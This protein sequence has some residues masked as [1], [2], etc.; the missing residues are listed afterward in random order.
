[1]PVLALAGLL[2]VGLGPTIPVD[3]RSAKSGLPRDLAGTRWAASYYN[4]HEDW[5]FVSRDSVDVCSGQ[6]G[7]SMPVDP[8]LID[9]DS[10]YLGCERTAYQLVD[11]LLILHR[12]ENGAAPDTFTWREGAFRSNWMFTYGHVVLMPWPIEDC[13]KHD[14]LE[15]RK[16]DR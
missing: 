13:S 11:S 1:M 7:W 4:Y 6:W 5:D 9:P 12:W 8:S 10:L 16:A 3:N 2:S 15:K 14:P